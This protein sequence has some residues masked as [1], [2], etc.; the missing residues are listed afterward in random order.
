MDAE[1]PAGGAVRRHGVLDQ[2]LA[3]LAPRAYRRMGA[4]PHTNGGLLLRDLDLPDFRAYAAEVDRPG[5]GATEGTR[6]LGRWLRT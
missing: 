4:N 3:A 6:P 1:L 2:E 5:A